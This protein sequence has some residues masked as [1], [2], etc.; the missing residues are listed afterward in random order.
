MTYKMLAVALA[1]VFYAAPANAQQT[2]PPYGA[3]ITL[4]VAKKVMA[5]AEA[6]AAR[7]NLAVVITIIDSGGNMVMMH[8]IDNTQL[9]SI[10]ASEGKAQTAL[11]FKRPS[12]QLEEAVA[13]GGAG[14]RLVGLK[15]IWPIEGGVPLLVDGKIVGAIGIS[16]ALSSQ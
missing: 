10:N 5:G 6:E 7:N 4:E 9:A 3:P 8:R 1:V 12:K 2:Q 16:G 11:A 14:L 15:N 13:A